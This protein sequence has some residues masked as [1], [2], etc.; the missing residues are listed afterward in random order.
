MY[1]LKAFVVVALAVLTP[2]TTCTSDVTSSMY[3]YL[4]NHLTPQECQ[5]FTVYLYAEGLEP[6]AVRELGKQIYC[7]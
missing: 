1:A 2:K 4:A 5:K 3:M 7:G 6:A